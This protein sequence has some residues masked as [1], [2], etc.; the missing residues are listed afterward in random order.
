MD[1]KIYIS[2]FNLDASMWLLYIEYTIIINM[3]SIF[4]LFFYRCIDMYKMF[5]F[6]YVKN[7]YRKTVRNKNK[8]IG[9]ISYSNNQFHVY[10]DFIKYFMYSCIFNQLESQ[11][12][13]E[14]KIPE[15]NRCLVRISLMSHSLRALTILCQALI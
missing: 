2:G 8:N 1:T 3:S 4:F 6:N 15:N 9:V 14:Y 5:F 11:L 13:V 10:F 12:S 7:I